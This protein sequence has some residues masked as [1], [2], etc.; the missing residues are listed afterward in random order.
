MSWREKSRRDWV[1]PVFFL[2]GNWSN[3]LWDT[4]NIKC[5]NP[6]CSSVT[7]WTYSQTGLRCMLSLVNI[8][9]VCRKPAL[10]KPSAVQWP[11]SRP[12]CQISVRETGCYWV[13]EKQSSSRKIW[14]L[15]LRI[16][17]NREA[18]RTGQRSQSR[19]C[20]NSPGAVTVLKAKD[21]PRGCWPS[22]Y[23]THMWPAYSEWHYCIMPRFS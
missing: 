18:I 14:H 13:L 5:Q 9:L 15:M 3:V 2:P 12:E 11:H 10:S 22:S 17:F 20:W 7:P 16:V 23:P 4:I 8:T 6:H 21:R 19:K 1:P